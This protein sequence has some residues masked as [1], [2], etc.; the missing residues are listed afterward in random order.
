MVDIIEITEHGGPEVMHLV[1]RNLD[2]PKENEVQIQ[3]T[4]VG[5]NYI[6][7][8]FRSGLYKPASLPFTP[9]NEGAGEVIKVG[10]AV[11][12]LKIG[13]RVAYAGPIGS[14][15]AA[16]NI[17][18]SKVVKIPDGISDQQAASM[19][20]KGMTAQYLLRQTY[21]VKKGDTILI[22]AAAGGV[23]LLV[24]QWANYLGARVIG[25]A[26]SQEKADLALANGAHDVIL[27]REKDFAE[28][29]AKLTNG[30]KCDVVYD[31]VGKDTYPGSLD[32][33]K[34][35]GLWVS[36]GQASGPIENFE[37][38]HLAQKGSLYATRPTLFNYIATPET[39]KTTANDLFDV[40]LKGVVK[41]E[42]S[43]SYALKD[44]AQ[45]HIDL[46]SRK[47]TG[48]TVLIP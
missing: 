13:D 11:N 16:R 24:C 2:A 22:H 36:Y 32:C 37:L 41:I 4:A 35:R 23:G 44:A 39:L 29:V 21:N 30:Q 31:A 42:V 40:V 15:A 10:S 6:D 43:Q 14:Y 1:S 47:T 19:M 3:Q 7:T 5:L 18:A 17:E 45:A 9:G 38:A 33:L 46:E 20:L 48:S 26:G 34:M 25:T 8:Y 28:E 27:Y 12:S